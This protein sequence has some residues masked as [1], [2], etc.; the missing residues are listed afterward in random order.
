MSHD[1][2]GE[3]LLCICSV[4][5]RHGNPIPDARVD[6]WETDSHGQYDVQYA[7]RTGPDGRC[8]IKSD[9]EGRFWYKAIRPVAYPIPDD[10]TVG[11][12]LRLLGRHP[13][14]PSH[15]HFMFEKEG[16][17]HLITYL[18]SFPSIYPSVFVP[19]NVSRN[20][21]NSGI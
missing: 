9:A 15:M 19:K 16:W 18:L 8:V 3:E 10:G 6:I 21:T 2:D 12:L 5:D 20:P 11:K 14:R 7:D 4:H 17:D 13:Y 1:P